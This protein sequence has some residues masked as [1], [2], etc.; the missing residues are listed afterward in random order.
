MEQKS[1]FSGRVKQSKKRG[2]GARQKFEEKRGGGPPS[3]AFVTIMG[4]FPTLAWPLLNPFFSNSIF[5]FLEKMCLNSEAV[6]KRSQS[7]LLW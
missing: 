3:V 1:T 7:T 2:R 6:A 4:T 5:I